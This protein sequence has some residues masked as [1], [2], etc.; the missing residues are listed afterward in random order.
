MNIPSLFPDECG[1]G[2]LGRLMAWNGLFKLDQ[3][4]GWMKHLDKAETRL[5]FVAGCSSLS[6]G[7]FIQEHTHIPYQRLINKSHAGV[8]YGM[9]QGICQV[10]QFRGLGTP[11]GRAALCMYCVREDIAFWGASYWRRLHQL[12]GVHQCSKHE[13]PLL[14]LPE[15]TFLFHSPE[16]VVAGAVAPPAELADAC[17][18]DPFVQRY[19]TLSEMALTMRMPQSPL[20]V[21]RVLEQRAKKL[22]L[23]VATYGK[24]EVLSDVVVAMASHPWLQRNFPDI[25]SKK[26]GQ[27]IG[28][29]DATCLNRGVAHQTPSYLLAFAALWDSAE[30]AMTECFLD[31]ISEMEGPVEERST[32]AINDF[33]RGIKL[34]EACRRNLV[35]LSDLEPL[36]RRK[37][38][39]VCS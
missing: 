25:A 1:Q 30:Q 8:P 35:S 36:L 32:A 19:C 39:L 7:V 26:P 6:L 23:R 31:Q 12:P 5:E 15:H 18:S 2:F 9:Q 29:I 28:S 27:F 38:N 10:T 22:G 21:S 17:A 34:R 16:D 3:L 37:L 11:R 33:K 4:I 14:D 20:R 24:C 13:A